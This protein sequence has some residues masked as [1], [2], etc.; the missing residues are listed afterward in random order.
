MAMFSILLLLNMPGVDMSQAQSA[1]QAA[2]QQIKVVEIVEV[3]REIRHDIAGQNRR[4]LDAAIDGVIRTHQKMYERGVKEGWQRE[5][6][7]NLL[8]HQDVEIAKCPQ[9]ARVWSL[10]DV[11]LFREKTTADLQLQ[12]VRIEKVDIRDLPALVKRHNLTQVEAMNLD[13]TV[14]SI[15]DGDGGIFWSPHVRNNNH[16]YRMGQ[17]YREDDLRLR[18][19]FLPAWVFEGS[20]VTWKQDADALVG[21]TSSGTCRIEFADG[22]AYRVSGLTLVND[23]KTTRYTLEDYREVGGVLLPCTLRVEQPGRKTVTRNVLRC[24]INPA[25]DA[26]AFDPPAGRMEGP[27]ADPAETVRP[28]RIP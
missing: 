10:N 18:L 11:F 24:E 23:G 9:L 2:W 16:Y 28:P 25:V 1:T 8:E 17:R 21:E 14:T 12:K 26:G 22:S 19:G 27:T 4:K 20:D 6:L 3:V 7:E 15:H 13:R 5:T